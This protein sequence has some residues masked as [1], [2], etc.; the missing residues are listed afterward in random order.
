[1]ETKT[2]NEVPTENDSLA[3]YLVVIHS[4]LDHLT[5]EQRGYLF[6]LMM[7]IVKEDPN[8]L[9]EDCFLNAFGLL[10]ADTLNRIE[11]VEGIV[12]FPCES[13]SS[14]GE[15]VRHAW[16][17]IDGVFV[18]ITAPLQEYV[19]DVLEGDTIYAGDSNFSVENLKAKKSWENAVYRGEVIPRQQMTAFLRGATDKR[20]EMEEK[21]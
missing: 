18:D 15:P 12:H 7:S 4:S 10:E 5:A 6:A 19:H 3:P 17:Q 11:Y 8:G 13:E 16:N 2:L 20:W 9:S 1:M 14:P 21:E